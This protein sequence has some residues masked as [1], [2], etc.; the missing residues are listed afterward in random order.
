MKAIKL[1]KKECRRAVEAASSPISH[2][3]QPGPPVP[4][5]R[6]KVPEHISRRTDVLLYGGKTL[7]QPRLPAL[8]SQ[9]GPVEPRDNQ[10][11]PPMS[12]EDLAAEEEAQ[13]ASEDP[14]IMYFDHTPPPRPDQHR[15]KRAAQ[16]QRW[17]NEVIPGLLPHFARLLQETKSLREMDAC[18]PTRNPCDCT[19][20]RHKIAIVRFSGMSPFR[21]LFFFC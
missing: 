7:T 2:A 21:L 14:D 8:F 4:H 17:Q 15:R 3:L 12:E 13:A 19:T 9:Y 16:W 10:P 20:K 5:Q 18:H 1:T 11:A 6:K